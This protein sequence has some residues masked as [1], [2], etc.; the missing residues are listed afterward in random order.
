[1]ALAL[2]ACDP[3]TTQT[4][5]DGSDARSDATD[6]IA[7]LDTS[8]TDATDAMAS[9][10]VTDAVSA[11]PTGQT[12]CGAVCVDAQNDAA[13]CGTCGHACAT[14]QSCVTG[15]CRCPGATA[16]CGAACVDTMTDSANCGAC[17]A[18]CP[19]GT[20]CTAGRCG[21]RPPCI[22]AACVRVMTCP[23]GAPEALFVSQDMPAATLAPG[24][25]LNVSVTFANCGTRTWSATAA[26]APTGTKL[27]AWAPMDNMTWGFNRVA[28]PADVTPGHAVEIPFTLH[29]PAT[30][31]SYVSSWAILNEGVA[32]L[33][34]ASPAVTL[35]VSAP[36][37]TVTLCPG[38]TADASGATGASAAIQ[39]CIDATPA[40]GTLVIPDGIYRIDAQLVINHPMTF[41]TVGLAAS[42]ANCLDAGT[43]CAT[44]QAATTLDVS[45]GMLLLAGTDHVVLDH[46]VL[47]GNRSARLGSMAAMRCAA[48]VNR[49]GF[50]AVNAASTNCSFLHSASIRA[51]CG[52]GFEWR[53]DGATVTG[54]VFRDNGENAVMNMWSDGLTLLQSDGARVVGNRFEN[55]SDVS[56]ISGGARGAT[57]QDNQFVQ[58]TQVVFAA[59]MMDNFNSSTSG[60]F[61]G[62]TT[63]GSVIACN[64]QLCHF[65]IQIGPHPWYLSTN[66]IAGTVTGNTVTGARQGMNIEGGGT[67]AAPVRVFANA[68]SGSPASAT[69][70]CGTRAT[71][72]VNISPDSF[73]DRNG[74]TA[75]VT[76][77]TWHDCP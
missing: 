48:G 25:S 2:G 63:S 46:I 70:L 5:P 61:T 66:T 77:R 21:T 13:N 71:S 49:N 58:S 47:D 53:G 60:D 24:A 16:A 44:L 69:F 37:R 42:V 34:G 30:T 1:M 4:G 40:G 39:R 23:A 65:G 62:T 67:A 3:G 57:F 9:P 22:G 10:D 31:G 38:E 26:S 12:L 51:L 36:S 54:S 35:T 28:L 14:G 45:G 59:F 56:F 52:S 11:C 29:A 18:A 17:G 55:N 20:T 19:T 76:A 7:T 8:P 68:V 43:S 74:E 73:V 41:G 50:N 72:N 27:G 15:A 64:A 33:P 6:R 32:W 75:A